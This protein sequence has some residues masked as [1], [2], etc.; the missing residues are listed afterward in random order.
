MKT[1]LIVME[2]YE[3]VYV[4]NHLSISGNFK[5]DCVHGLS[6]STLWNAYDK[7]SMDTI[8]SRVKRREDF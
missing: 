8:V 6:Q 2:T 7:C 4:I 3:T 1:A 5:Y